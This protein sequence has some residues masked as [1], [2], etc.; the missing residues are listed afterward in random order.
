MH[1]RKLSL[2]L[3]DVLLFPDAVSCKHVHVFWCFIVDVAFLV[4]YLQGCDVVDDVAISNENPSTVLLHGVLSASHGSSLTVCVELVRALVSRRSCKKGVCVKVFA[5]QATFLM[6]AGS[7]TGSLIGKGMTKRA[8][9][10]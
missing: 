2:K 10:N 9:E 5:T 8:Y 3:A 4:L 1:A 6:V 7:N